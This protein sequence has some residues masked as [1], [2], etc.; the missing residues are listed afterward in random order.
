MACLCL[1]EGGAASDAIPA[2]MAA[3]LQALIIKSPALIC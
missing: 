3:G 2:A 1:A